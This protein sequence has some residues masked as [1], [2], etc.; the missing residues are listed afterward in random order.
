[1]PFH[2]LLVSLSATVLL[3]II[4][5]LSITSLH[6]RSLDLICYM[7]GDRADYRL[8]TQIIS[9]YFAKKAKISL[10]FTIIVGSCCENR[11]YTFG[12]EY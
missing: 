3:V 7:A 12:I 2:V 5:L 6:R 1:M 4:F 10:F 8:R 11:Q 9:I